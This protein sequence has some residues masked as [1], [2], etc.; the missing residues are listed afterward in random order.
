MAETNE[1]VDR[2]RSAAGIIMEDTSPLALSPMPSTS[3]EVDTRLRELDKACRDAGTL[4]H[5]A[6]ILVRRGIR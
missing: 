6:Q 5:A 2:L 1:L 3:E 4:I